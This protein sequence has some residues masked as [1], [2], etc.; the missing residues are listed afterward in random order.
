MQLELVGRQGVVAADFAKED[1]VV[2]VFELHMVAEFV[3]CRGGEVA[4]VTLTNQAR[5]RRQL[6]SSTNDRWDHQARVRADLY[7]LLRPVF[8]AGL[9]ARFM[10]LALESDLSDFAS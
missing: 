10:A 1:I 3:H 6:L 4:Q 8:G 7:L 5:A 2:V 9:M